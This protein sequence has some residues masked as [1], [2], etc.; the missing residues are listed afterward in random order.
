MNLNI[1]TSKF[2]Q[3]GY[4]FNS[5][6]LI[7]NLIALVKERQIT[8]LLVFDTLSCFSLKNICRIH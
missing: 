3:S 4:L 5:G 7:A 6:N 1:I 8:L 2:K